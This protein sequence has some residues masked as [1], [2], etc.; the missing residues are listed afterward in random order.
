MA[1]VRLSDVVVP[2]SFT[3]YVVQ[4]TAENSSLVQSGVMARNAEIEAQLRAGADRFTVPVWL[5]LGNEEANIVNDDPDDEAVPKK[6][7]ST[8]YKVRKA[9][10]HQS[11]SAMNL[12]SELAGDNALARIQSRVEAYWSRQLQR[13]LIATL[14]GVL[15][16]NIANDS[17]DMLH[18]ASGAFG[19]AA[20]IDAAAT[21]GDA[22][23]DLRAIAMHSDTYT[24][25][26]KNDL[27]ATIPD[28]RG[29]F[30]QTFRGMAVIVDDMVTVDRTD[31][32]AP[33]YTSVLFGPGAIGYGITE[34]RIAAGTE[35]ENRPAAGN[36]GG[37]QVLHSRQNVAVH[38]AGFSFTDASVADESPSLAELTLATNWDRL[39]P[40]KHVPLAFLRHG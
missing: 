3:G 8:S 39:A 26:L 29:G 14:N 12:A 17:G 25:A 22:M 2:E 1:T 20:V 9:Y 30:I 36:G 27:I 35:I 15:A 32:D 33:L 24:V 23:R 28:S 21:L 19:A 37:Q 38:P 34:P 16:D 40:R 11:W 13:R 18:T 31:P 10:L 7:G 6:I 5:D 4:N